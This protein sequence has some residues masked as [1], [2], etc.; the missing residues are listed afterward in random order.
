M[1]SISLD[2]RIS[3]FVFP[4]SISDFVLRSS[5]RFLI[6]D[7]LVFWIPISISFLL[8]DFCFWFRI[9]IFRILSFVLMIFV[10]LDFRI[11]VFVFPI[12]ISDFVLRSSTQF[13]IFNFLIF[14]IL[15]SISFLL[16]DFRFRFCILSFVFMIFVSLDFRISDFGFR[17][18]VF[19]FDFDLIFS[20]FRF[21][22]LF[23][24]LFLWFPF[25]RVF[26]A[27]NSDSVFSFRLRV[28]GFPIS[29]SDRVPDFWFLISDFSI[30]RIPISIS[31]FLLDFRFWFC[32]LIFRISLSL[33]RSLR[34]S[35]SEALALSQNLSQPL[36]LH[37]RVHTLHIAGQPQLCIILI[38]QITILLCSYYLNCSSLTFMIFNIKIF[39]GIVHV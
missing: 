35:S 30:F 23:M 7:F 17:L 27:S 38:F 2:F 37:R 18:R 19:D 39:I 28:F 1:I 34:I 9:L 25:F 13:L 12:W 29:Y 5:T 10:S 32:I 36:L 33:S 16:L 31:F 3:H 24:I 20:C 26:E 4:I 11:S 14:W 22:F 6:F 8:L 15:I 21:V